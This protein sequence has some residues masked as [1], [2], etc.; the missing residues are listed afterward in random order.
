MLLFKTLS[1]S[2][3]LTGSCFIFAERIF[4]KK[5]KFSENLSFCIFY[6]T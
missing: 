2:W 5:D 3:A 6:L 1:F 4:N